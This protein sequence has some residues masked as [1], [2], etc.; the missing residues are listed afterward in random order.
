MWIVGGAGHLLASIASSVVW[1][2]I[3]AILW[4]CLCHFCV[5]AAYFWNQGTA[6][7]V[8]HNTRSG[9]N[10][11]GRAAISR[12]VIISFCP[13]SKQPERVKLDVDSR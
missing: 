1:L 5:G 11:A 3:T 8:M 10:C 7:G 6:A 13:T 12:F 9:G 4:V 2:M